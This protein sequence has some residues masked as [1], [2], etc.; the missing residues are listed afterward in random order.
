[1]NREIQAGWHAL[2]LTRASPSKW[3]CT[4]KASATRWKSNSPPLITAW[5]E[6][7]EIAKIADA[8]LVPPTAD[9]RLA[10]LQERA[11]HDPDA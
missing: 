7:E 8:L 6:A 1:M 5:R 2:R 10:V 11:R 3:H 4:R 9:A